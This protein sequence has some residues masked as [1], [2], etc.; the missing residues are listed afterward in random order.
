MR[1]SAGVSPAFLRCDEIGKI[2]GPSCIGTSE[3]RAPRNTCAVRIQGWPYNL[4]MLAAY[5]AETQAC[6]IIPNGVLSRYTSP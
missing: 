6:G 1:C 5:M 3:R 4:Q 2:A